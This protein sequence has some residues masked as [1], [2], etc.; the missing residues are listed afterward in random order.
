MKLIMAEK[1]KP[2]LIEMQGS[3]ESRNMPKATD[4]PMVLLILEAFFNTLPQ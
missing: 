3:G 4:K 1:F 2:A